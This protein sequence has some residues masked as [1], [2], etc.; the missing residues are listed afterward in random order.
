MIGARDPV[1]DCLDAQL[2]V[3]ENPRR[4]RVGFS[5]G[6]DS[7]VL[8]HALATLRE[9]FGIDL[10]AVHVDHQLSGES[11]QWARH[12]RLFC[13]RF[14][15]PCQVLSVD[16]RAAAGEGPEAAARAARYAALSGVLETDEVLATAHHADDQAETVLL[17][18]LRGSGPAG[19]AAMP[20]WRRLGA[21]WLWRPLLLLSSQTVQDYRH[22]HHLP[23][24]EDPSNQALRFD[25]NFLRHRI[26]PELRSR[27]PKMVESIGRAAI[28]QGEVGELARTLAELDYPGGLATQR[29]LSCER[30]HAMSPARAR[31]LLR[32]WLS[33]AGLSVPHRKQLERILREAVAAGPDRQPV[34]GWPGGEVRRYRGALYAMA[35]LPPMTLGGACD[36][37]ARWPWTPDQPL[38]LDIGSLEASAVRG[39]GLAARLIET[40]D[41]DCG[42]WVRFRRGGERCRPLG[43][44]HTQTLKRLFQEQ[45]VE[46]WLR[47]RIPLVFV[48]DRLAAVAGRWVCHDFAAGPA[49]PGWALRWTPS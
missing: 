8:L 17:N 43:R 31:N 18:L 29:T 9:R 19:L 34:V 15:I 35:P 16:A 37:N 1:I 2:G 45:G 13:Q 33:V 7:V 40:P 28:A 48:G 32:H 47:D 30:L 20:V 42:L 39:T 26:L 27:W 38:H 36:P 46:P 24:I 6:G 10:N 3:L 5:G 23:L 12:C 41:P 25:R 49:E 11:A 44:S 14:A 22:Q 4:V 21:G